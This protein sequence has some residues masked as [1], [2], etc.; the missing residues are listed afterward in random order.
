MTDS[1]KELGEF[2]KVI[3]LDIEGVIVTHKSILYNHT[4][5]RPY[6]G[7]RTPVW[8]SYIDQLCLGLVY[9][10]AMDFAAQIVVTSTLRNDKYCHTGL[11]ASSPPWLG[12]NAGDYLSTQVTEHRGSR[13]E[14]IALFV[15]KFKVTQYVVFDDRDL[16]C[17][18]FIRVDQYDGLSL[19]N[20]NKAKQFLAD[21]GAEIKYEGIYL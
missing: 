16:E 18:N 4:P 3:F 1:D 9:K 17:P 5:D 7:A 21:E 12:D 20:Y 19:H 14:E 8:N 6:R 13:E 15:E 11:L 2:H 10:L